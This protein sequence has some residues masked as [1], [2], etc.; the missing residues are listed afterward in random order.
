MPPPRRVR[1][2]AVL[3]VC[4]PENAPGV[5]EASVL[6]LSALSEGLPLAK[7]SVSSKGSS[8]SRP[9]D[10]EAA[11]STAPSSEPA[12]AAPPAAAAAAADAGEQAA[13]EGATQEGGDTL[14]ALPQPKQPAA[15]GARSLLLSWGMGRSAHVSA[16]HR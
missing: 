3:M 16:Y 15:R 9:G 10:S 13:D 8:A 7:D 12:A 1:A 11:G 14:S 2:G 5:K 6:N 4:T